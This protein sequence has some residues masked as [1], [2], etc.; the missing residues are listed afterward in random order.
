M[1]VIQLEPH[2]KQRADIKVTYR[3][4]S[5]SS[6][7]DICPNMKQ[8][9]RRL[10]TQNQKLVSCDLDT[11]VYVYSNMN[12]G[13]HTPTWEDFPNSICKRIAIISN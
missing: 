4:G 12:N 2:L 1:S 10:I 11:D 6:M 5:K 7:V 9:S 13:G 3:K 8:R